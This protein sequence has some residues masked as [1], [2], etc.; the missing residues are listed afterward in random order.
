MNVRAP[1]PASLRR[2]AS[3]RAGRARPGFEPGDGI[4]ND[5]DLRYPAAVNPFDTQPEG[6]HV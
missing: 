6:R 1:V 3:K 5:T 2:G 4:R